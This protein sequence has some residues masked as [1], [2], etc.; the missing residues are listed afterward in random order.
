VGTRNP[1]LG[2]AGYREAAG[3][4]SRNSIS[5]PTPPRRLGKG[6]STSWTYF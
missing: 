6:P 3:R 5:W 4:L 1:L 2:K